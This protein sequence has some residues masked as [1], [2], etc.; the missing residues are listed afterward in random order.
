MTHYIVSNSQGSLV[1][2]TVAGDSE[3][4][5][6]SNK[7]SGSKPKATDTV[8]VQ[9]RPAATPRAASQKQTIKP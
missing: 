3:Q 2:S 7:D 1:K 4:S 6:D 9:I 5:D 8:A